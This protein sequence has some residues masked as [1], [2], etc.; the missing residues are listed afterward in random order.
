MYRY[1]YLIQKTTPGGGTESGTVATSS[2]TNSSKENSK[3]D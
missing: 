1:T 2:S 3:D